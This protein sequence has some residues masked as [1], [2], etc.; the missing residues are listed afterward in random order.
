M[1]LY[2]NPHSRRI[3]W[4]GIL[5]GL[6]MGLVTTMAILALGAIITALTGITL[7]GWQGVL[8]PQRS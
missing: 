5:A 6:V 1:T 3:S 4:S 8:S 2:T 7:A